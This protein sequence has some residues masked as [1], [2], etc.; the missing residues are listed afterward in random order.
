MNTGVLTQHPEQLLSLY[1]GVLRIRVIEEAICTLYGEQEMRCPVHI[2]IGQEAVAVGACAAL[3]PNDYAV[4]GHRSHGH[5]LAKGGDL[6]AMLAEIYGKSTGCCSG[7]GGSMH[8]T[9]LAAGFL[10]STPIV[11]STIPIGV[12][13]A[14]AARMRGEDSVTMVFLGDGATE[15]GVFHESL[16]FAALKQLPVVFVCENNFYSVYSPLEVRQAKERPIRDLAIGHGIK[17]ELGDGNDAEEVYR[18]TRDAVDLARAG[19]GPIFLEF[20]TYRWREHC[21]PNYDN[22]IG[23][24]TEDEFQS[25]KLADPVRKLEERLLQRDVPSDHLLEIRHRLE[26]EMTAAVDFAKQSP[27]PQSAAMTANVYAP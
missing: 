6:K 1:T 4:S 26:Q 14:F 18:M 13:A 24:R 15:A 20:T 9:D 8:L 3:R 22:D 23:Y 17:S 12:G 5:Y 2:C 16:G 10:G 27:F 25:W 7:V 11:G 21:G 19:K